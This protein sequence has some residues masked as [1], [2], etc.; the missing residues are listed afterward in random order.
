MEVLEFQDQSNFFERQLLVK[1][2]MTMYQPYMEKK[3]IEP[4][5]SS[6]HDPKIVNWDVKDKLN[7]TKQLIL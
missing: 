3:S 4:R 2:R 1:K 6:R 7:Q 5:V